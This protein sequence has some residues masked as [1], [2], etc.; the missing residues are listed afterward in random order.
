[1]LKGE[2]NALAT[3]LFLKGEKGI[4]ELTLPLLVGSPKCVQGTVSQLPLRK[5]CPIPFFLSHHP[6]FKPPPC[7]LAGFDLTTSNSAGC[8]KISCFM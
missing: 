1:V 6:V 7:I 4:Q 5:K 3:K 2:I 8:E